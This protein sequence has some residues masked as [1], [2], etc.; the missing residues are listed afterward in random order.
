[1]QVSWS[2]LEVDVPSPK[3]IGPEK[4]AEG[5]QKPRDPPPL[6]V[7]ALNIK[8]VL[9]AKVGPLPLSLPISIAAAR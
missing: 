8:T 1:L 7:A 5:T 3:A 9:D 2:K 4:F 6:V